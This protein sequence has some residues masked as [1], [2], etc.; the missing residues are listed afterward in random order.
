MKKKEVEDLEQYDF[1]PEDV[2]HKSE[3][4][5]ADLIGRLLIYFSSI[6]HTLNLRIAHII[7]GRSHEPGYTVIERL[8]MDNKIDLYFNLYLRLAHLKGPAR[9]KELKALRARSK[10]A[11]AFRNVV[12]HA[13]WFSLT[14]GGYV[15]SKIIVNGDEG[16]VQFKNV[17]LTPEDIRRHISKFDQLETDLDEFSYQISA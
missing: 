17:K 6:E 13:N 5:Y 10:E 15:R 14:K 9:V 7:N 3:D 12:V 11:C 16:H 2:I 1:L 8:S 4:K